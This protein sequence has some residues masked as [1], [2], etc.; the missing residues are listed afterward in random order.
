MVI[1]KNNITQQLVEYM[2]EKIQSGEWKVGQKIPSENDLA[3]KLNVSRASVHAAIQRFIALGMIKSEQGKGTF[4]CSD[5]TEYLGSKNASDGSNESILDF[6]RFRLIFEPEICYQAAKNMSD[7]TLRML[8]ENYNMMRRSIGDSAVF[9]E[10]D[11]SFHRMIGESLGN[12]FVDQLMNMLYSNH[13]Y[14]VLLTDTYGFQGLYDHKELLTA[15]RRHDAEAA[16]KSMVN[17]LLDAIS[18]IT[19]PTV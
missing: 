3:K 8:E 10:Y 11:L 15:F 2:R 18:R 4:L 13:Q 14:A 19:K 16:K 12:R 17:Q 9:S 1:Q 6:L 5:H 7:E